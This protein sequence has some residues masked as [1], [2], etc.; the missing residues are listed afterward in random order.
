M[1]VQP[2]CEGGHANCSSSICR[3]LQTPPL[4]CS[5]TKCPQVWTIETMNVRAHHYER[6]SFFGTRAKL[7]PSAC[8]LMRFSLCWVCL[9]LLAAALS[10]CATL[11]PHFATICL[12]LRSHMLLA[13]P[14]H[15]LTTCATPL[16]PRRFTTALP[17]LRMRW[18]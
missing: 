7:N 14:P 1:N 4:G 18:L 16:L 2:K 15:G 6:I 17:F 10:I 13:S 5:R 9:P 3:R 8:T 11:F 12:G